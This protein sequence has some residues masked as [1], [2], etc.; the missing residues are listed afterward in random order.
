MTF[1]YTISDFYLFILVLGISLAISIPAVWLMDGFIPN[2]LR[3]RENQGIGY[4]SATIC[5]IFAVLAGFAA[6]YVLNNFNQADHATQ[7]EAD[8]AMALYYRAEWITNPA[9][10]EIQRLVKEYFLAAIEHDWPL[11]AKGKGTGNRIESILNEM[12]GSLHHY[13]SSSHEDLFFQHEILKNIIKLREM[14]AERVRTYE[15]FLRPHIWI[16]ITLGA[17]LTIAI[18]FFFGMNRSLHYLLIIFAC[19]I[20]ASVVFL[21]IILDHPY[22]GDFSVSSGAFEYYLLLLAS[23]LL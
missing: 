6:L 17:L 23:V 3:Y 5:V 15:L 1:L 21:L 14:H 13:K 11:M 18:N 9:R 19:V 22:Q 10:L 16:V 20:V 12:N 2:E 7:Q 4:F 8:E